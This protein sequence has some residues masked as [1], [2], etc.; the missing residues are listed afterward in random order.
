MSTLKFLD[1]V[2]FKS[3]FTFV[4][5]YSELWTWIIDRFTD[6][7]FPAT[8]AR[9]LLFL[10]NLVFLVNALAVVGFRIMFPGKLD[11]IVLHGNGNFRFQR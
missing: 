6:M 2:A 11:H 3:P 7:A 10:L 5:C 9:Y 1:F 4:L 8:S